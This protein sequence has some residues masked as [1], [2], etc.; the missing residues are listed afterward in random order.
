MPIKTNFK[1]KNPLKIRNYGAWSPEEFAVLVI[2]DNSE[3]PD[4]TDDWFAFLD[5]LA[6]MRDST[7]D[8][9]NIGKKRSGKTIFSITAID[10]IMKADNDRFLICYQN[11]N[12]PKILRK[13]DRFKKRVSSINHIIE[14]DKFVELGFKLIIY[15]DEGVLTANAKSA[16]QKD[17]KELGQAFASSSHKDVILIVNAQDDGVIKDLRG[18]GDISVFKRLTRRYILGSSDPLVRSKHELLL[19]LTKKESYVVSEHFDF[20]KTGIIKFDVYDY[21]DWLTPE[22][23]KELS[24]NDSISSF[25]Q[26]YNKELE[27]LDT[28]KELALEYIDNKGLDYCLKYKNHVKNLNYF[29]TNEYSLKFFKQVE[30]LIPKIDVFINGISQD[31]T[32]ETYSKK[33]DEK[34]VKITKIIKENKNVKEK[35]EEEIKEIKEV[36]KRKKQTGLITQPFYFPFSQFVESNLSGLHEDIEVIM[37]Y[38]DGL[39]FRDIMKEKNLESNKTYKIVEK[40]VK[41]DCDKLFVKYLNL[42]TG[43]NFEYKNGYIIDSKADL[44]GIETVF[45]FLYFKNKQNF[46]YELD[47]QTLCKSAIEEAKKRK[48][49]TIGIFIYNRKW[50]KEPILI[51]FDITLDKLKIMKQKFNKVF[52]VNNY[53]F[54]TCNKITKKRIKKEKIEDEFEYLF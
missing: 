21:L 35:K 15:M 27:E 17:M 30:H 51:R 31:Y 2:D 13:V 20:D 32:G 34:K 38:L 4:I 37:L 23:D 39:S 1:D 52:K 36:K 5:K 46:T 49:D 42:I 3:I 12:L 14:A 18:K 48:L 41:N 28:V 7:V 10:R 11:E 43:Y 8:I 16:L 29:L 26:P 45:S 54:K 25:S 50:C 22:L 19:S 24:K 6:I 53:L 44:T 47:I 40:F 9:H 33:K